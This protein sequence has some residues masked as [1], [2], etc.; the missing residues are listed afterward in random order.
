MIKEKK[1]IFHRPFI[2]NLLM[3]GQPI[4][5]GIVTSAMGSWDRTTD[6]Y[7]NLKLL[8][9][10]V[11]ILLEIL[12]L[13]KYTK[14]DKEKSDQ[15]KQLQEDLNKNKKER[16]ILQDEVLDLSEI[17]QNTAKKL[18]ELAHNIIERSEYDGHIWN[19]Q[20]ACERICQAAYKTIRAVA[21]AG[22]DF[23]VSY[24]QKEVDP[25]GT[26]YLEMPALEGSLD[27]PDIKDHKV[28]AQEVANYFYARQFN[29]V[30]PQIVVLSN[31]EE[32][33]KEFAFPKGGSSSQN[34]YEQYIGIPVICNNHDMIG[35]LQII[36][37]QNCKIL[38]T[39]TELLEMAN[40]F[41]LPFA[42]YAMFMNKIE[43]AAS[44]LP[45]KRITDERRKGNGE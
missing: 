40:H 4:I 18:N 21:I 33:L 38:N 32:I 24:I 31:N 45:K 26:V 22:T 35:L 13:H 8:I 11:S 12:I 27:V 17:A 7:F 34:K 39:R 5:I 1:A 19:Y 23:S 43:K 20:M 9:L 41:L 36:A 29:S 10:I 25:D 37:H 14:W 28:K 42:H 15:V 16:D 6:R 44:A 2:R 3:T 30:K